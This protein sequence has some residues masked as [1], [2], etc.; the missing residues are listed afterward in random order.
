M[1]ELCHDA[2]FGGEVEG[3]LSGPVELVFGAVSL[4]VSAVVV[5]VEVVEPAEEHAVAGFCFPVLG[6]F[7]P[8]VDVVGLAGSG[9]HGAA[10]D[11]AAAVA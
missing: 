5:E 3:F 9:W 4:D 6:P 2:V 11:E 8:G 7:V 1:A 10:G